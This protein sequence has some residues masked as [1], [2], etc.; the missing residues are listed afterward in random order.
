MRCARSG[1]C[2]SG[3][4]AQLRSSFGKRAEPGGTDGAE[5]T[6]PAEIAR[7]IAM[8]FATTAELKNQT[9]D[10]LH[11]IEAGQVVVVTRHGK[12]VA[13][14]QVCHEDDSRTSCSKRV[15]RFGSLSG[16]PRQIFVAGAGSN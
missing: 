15:P 14:I 5:L 10:L 13:A 4:S 2:A 12:P 7:I 8:K 16:V 9:N 11:E 6:V 3:G 1:W